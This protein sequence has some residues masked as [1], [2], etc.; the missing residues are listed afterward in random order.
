MAER[1]I[2]IAALAVATAVAI[3][4][5]RTW[6]ARRTQLLQTQLPAWDAL[7]DKP[8]GRPTL[9]AFSSPSCATCHIAQSPAID[10]AHDRLGLDQLRVINVDVA[11]QPQVARAFGVLTVPST[12]VI[13]AHGTQ[14]VAVNHGFAP[15]GR[16]LEQLQRA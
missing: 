15:S 1:L 10:L 7:G 3:A 6:T 9:I 16:L 4:L 2:V 14:I 11:G 5:V 12:V 13:G 8:D